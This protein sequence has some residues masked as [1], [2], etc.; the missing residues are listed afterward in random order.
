MQNPTTTPTDDHAVETIELAIGGMTCASCVNRIEKKLNRL[1]G[2]SASVNLATERATVWF[3]PGLPT[4]DLIATVE[5]AGYTARPADAGAAGPSTDRA[6]DGQPGEAAEEAEAGHEDDR[7]LTSLKRTW[8]VSLTVGLAMMVVMYVPIGI[9]TMDLL[10]P[11]LLVV[12]TFI[13]VWAGKRFYVA[14]WQ[15]ARHGSTN[16]NTLV[17]LGTS[18]AYGYS[19]FVTLWPGPAQSWGLPLHVYFE[20]S[21]VI[22]AL[23]TMGRWLEA[24]AKKQTAAAVR[25]LMGLQPRTARVLR[26]GAEVDV[27][28]ESVQVGDVVRVRPGEKVPVDGV[29]S[30]GTSAVDESMITGESLPVD[31]SEG[32]AVIGATVN[33]AGSLLV[34]TTAV[35]RDTTLA[36]IIRLVESAQGSKAPMQRLADRVASWFI[37]AVLVIAAATF[38]GWVLFGPDGERLTLAIGTTIA[39]LI[40]ACPCALGLATPVAVMVGTG[41]AAE[42]GVLITS[43]EALEQ[44]RR[45]TAVVLDK[46][47]TITLGRPTVTAVVPAE[48]WSETDL[49]RLV[50]SAELGSEHPLGEAVVTAAKDRGVELSGPQ[51]FAAVP[52]HGIEAEVAGRRVQ[53]GNR[54][55]LDG[56][57]LDSL[58]DAAERGARSG[59]TP[60]YVA[61]DG[62]PAGLLLV[63]DP[64]KP[65]SADAV[66]ELAALCLE[67]WMITGDNADTATATARQV[68]VDHVL[69]EVLPQDKAARVAELQAAGH[70]VAMVGDGINDAPALAQAD[71][72]MAIGTGT[73]VAIAASDITLV[74]GDLRKIVSAISLSRSTVTTIKQGLFWAFAYNVLLIPV[75]AGLLYW[76][77][78]VLL[79]P[80]LAAAAMAMSSVSVVT[81]AL[82]LRSFRPASSA[83]EILHPNR[84]RQVQQYTYLAGIAV[85]ALIVG[86]GLTS[87]SRTDTAQRGMNGLLEWTEGVGMTMRPAMSEMMATEV[88]PVSAEHAGLDVRIDLP[89]NVAPGEPAR[90]VLTVVDSETGQPVTDL[91]R[92][93]EA[94]MHV[95]VTRADLG[96]FAHLHPEPTG[97]PGQLAVDVTFP[98]GGRY[99]VHTEFRRQGEMADVLQGQAVTVAGPTGPPARL[100]PGSRTQVADGVAVR[101]DGE[102]VADE[103][104]ELEL[105]FTD[106]GTGEPVTGLQPYLAAAGHVIVMRSDGAFFQH[107]H[108]EETG[109]DGEPVFALP[110]Q[111]FGPRLDLHVTFPTAG[112]YRMWGQFR[113]ADGSV[114]AVP[115]TVRVRPHG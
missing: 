75:A 41:K 115:Y 52:G 98:T 13:Q 63:A 6:T 90:A 112:V 76:W 54:R 102:P 107:A 99:L 84:G 42:L 28:I 70:V 49:L 33:R 59:A 87:L 8:Q 25:A 89:S 106:A 57:R 53:V 43:G 93:H 1:D 23:I 64:P 45:L 80:V 20:T 69:A 5:K 101:L 2:V 3:P 31:K 11:A 82:R 111:T 37:P 15:A 51:R 62:E 14:A 26:D 78:G 9:D 56:L 22:I 88:E 96:T 12:A 47:G 77:D 114:V 18:V 17:A 4:E 58:A 7:E 50:G 92:N 72:G 108:A 100:T 21:V 113:L 85:L 60:M 103:D 74:G 66:T 36:Q 61:I 95:V 67:V 44:A 39:V 86:G 68:G 55:L 91:T 30:E 104:T 24:R 71:L 27:P 105:S 109:P 46:T 16:M 19:A 34:R 97:E 79:D 83:H 40:V 94:W 35:G 73:D 48:G 29:V 110:G 10:M 81:N 38:L 65:E 32:D